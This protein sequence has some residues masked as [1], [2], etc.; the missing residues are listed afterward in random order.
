MK[1]PR[2]PCSDPRK[3]LGTLLLVFCSFFLLVPDSTAGESIEVLNPGFEEELDGGVAE[4]LFVTDPDHTERAGGVA[5]TAELRR[6]TENAHAGSA[7]ALIL[8]EGPRWA[9]LRQ[10]FALEPGGT[11][12]LT[13]F[14]R[15]EE[16]PVGR[17]RG[18]IR[19]SSKVKSEDFVAP[20]DGEEGAF[21]INTFGEWQKFTK[22]FKVSESLP[23]KR[24]VHLELRAI[25][26]DAKLSEPLKI[27]FDSVTLERLD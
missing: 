8:H 14:A 3:S 25:P 11:Y 7:S 4:W 22:D 18:S 27:W 12:R 17:L 1:Y 16:H 26:V 13:A 15:T 23:D 10:S 6:D 9:T 19:L 5:T 24:K 20:V 21:D 2:L